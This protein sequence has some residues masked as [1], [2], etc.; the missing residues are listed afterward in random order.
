MTRPFI[1]YLVGDVEISHKETERFFGTIYVTITILPLI[2]Y[3]ISSFLSS[4]T[5]LFFFKSI[6]KWFLTLFTYGIIER[7]F[8]STIKFVRTNQKD[9]I[10]QSEISKDQNVHRMND[11]IFTKINAKRI[12]RAAALLFPFQGYILTLVIV[13]QLFT[14]NQSIE[15][16]TTYQ[17]LLMNN[18]IY[19]E[20]CLIKLKSLP[21]I[22]VQTFFNPLTVFQPIPYAPPDINVSSFCL[23]SSTIQYELLSINY[24]IQC[25]QYFFRWNNIINALTNALQWH[26]IT[27]FIIKTI[28]Y[29]T[30][31][32][33]NSL[34]H[35]QRWLKASK[36]YRLSILILLTILWTVGF[37][38]YVLILMAFNKAVASSQVILT[39]QTSAV[40]LIPTFV[41]PLLFYNTITLFH[42]LIRTIRGKKCEQEVALT[43]DTYR[44]VLIYAEDNKDEIYSYVY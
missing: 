39:F 22:P 34:G 10:L 29:F 32:W 36:L 18:S 5:K 19:A 42:W 7:I 12:K 8:L 3:I 16:C 41:I 21:D 24:H 13:D 4:I 28:L 14:L 33:Q 25:T 40:L 17:Q 30:F 44:N 6:A 2:I 35:S 38:I 1:S 31:S 43:F 37:V 20:Q 26:Q 15:T 9:F 27:I 23:N 11:K